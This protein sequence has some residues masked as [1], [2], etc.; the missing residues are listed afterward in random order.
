MSRQTRR[1]RRSLDRQQRRAAANE[2]IGHEMAWWFYFEPITLPGIC[3]VLAAA[4]G[5]WTW[6]HVNHRHIAAALAGLGVL[7][8]VG[9]AGWIA[10][11]GVHRRMMAVARGREINRGM[12]HLIGAAGVALV[13]A[14]LAL[15]RSAL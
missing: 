10:R 8:L 7:L 1:D 2:R 14:G 5:W 3:V 6:T 15:M 12:W 13:A 4:A 9:Y 11:N